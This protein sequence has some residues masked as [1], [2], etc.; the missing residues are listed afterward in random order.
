MLT[1]V[2]RPHRG[3]V[4]INGVDASAAPAEARAALGYLPE[5]AAVYSEMSVRGY[6][7]H[8]ASFMGMRGRD[9]RR[10]VRSA[11]ERCG[12]AGVAGRRAGALSKGF[13][14]RLALAGAIVHD[15]PVLVLDEPTNGLDPTQ[16]REARAL[17]ADLSDRR[18]VIVCSHVLGEIERVCERVAIIAAG[19]V[20]AQGAIDELR[21]G[22]APACIAEVMNAPQRLAIPGGRV[23][24]REP[25][26]DGWERLRIESDG[27]G[28]AEAV[29]RAFAQSG[30]VVRRLEPVGRTLEDVFLGAMAGAD[31]AKGAP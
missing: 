11:M 26:G 27:A 10:A 9:R 1:G 18:T 24:R 16:L 21:A 6:L 17:I 8:R 14:Q 28:I 4:L 31:P 2:L 30:A 15:P 12:I 13:R 3:T 19:R 23:A 22:H 7:A 5:S 20:L 29:G 25:M